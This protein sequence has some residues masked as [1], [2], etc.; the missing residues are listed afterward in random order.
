MEDWQSLTL[1][2]ATFDRSQMIKKQW[3]EC[4]ATAGTVKRGP[5]LGKASGVAEGWNCFLG[6]WEACEW[7]W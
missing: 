2:P 6:G 3:W 7:E 1:A 4:K 5:E